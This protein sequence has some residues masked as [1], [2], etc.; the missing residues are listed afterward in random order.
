MT[1]IC[2]ITNGDE[3]ILGCDQRSGDFMVPTKWVIHGRPVVQVDLE[4]PKA[5]VRLDGGRQWAIGTS[6]AHRTQQLI[7]RAT[8][9]DTDDPFR[10]STWIRDL[11]LEDGYQPEP[12]NYD[13]PALGGGIL[14][15][16]PGRVWHVAGCFSTVEVRGFAATGSGRMYAD[17]A[18]WMAQRRGAGPREQI[19]EAVQSAI[20]LDRDGCGGE[21]VVCVL[22][23][24]W[25]GW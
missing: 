5:I 14:L 23:H 11:L 4:S 3:T 21:A 15:A 1:I 6:G 22:G 10:V 17:G 16:R 18:A 25:A 24:N 7:E 9:P 19:Y 8:I 13:P 20:A 12:G 2:A